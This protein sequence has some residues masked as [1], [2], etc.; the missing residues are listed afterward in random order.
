MHEISL[1]TPSNAVDEIRLACQISCLGFPQLA[2]REERPRQPLLRHVVEHVALVL[3]LVE[4]LAQLGASSGG[5]IEDLRAQIFELAGQEFNV[6]SL[7]FLDVDDSR[8]IAVGCG[9]EFCVGCFTGAYPVEPPQPQ[10]RDK[11]LDKYEE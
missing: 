6:D 9:C 7:G 10:A 2:E 1:L 4:R 3:R 8:K 5:Q 11:Y